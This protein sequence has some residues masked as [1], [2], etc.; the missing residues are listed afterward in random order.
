MIVDLSPAGARYLLDI[1]RMDLRFY[2]ELAGR[3]ECSQANRDRWELVKGLR[4][5]L[6]QAL[7]ENANSNQEN[8]SL[9]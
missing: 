4:D 8:Q 5:A 2:E 6:T 1:L 9:R 7:T 3:K